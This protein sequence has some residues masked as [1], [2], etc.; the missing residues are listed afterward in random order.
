MHCVFRADSGGN[1][2]AN[3]KKTYA[4][5]TD[6][7]NQTMSSAYIYIR[8]HQT[9]CSWIKQSA[10]FVR[11]NWYRLVRSI[12]Q[13]YDLQ[14]T[15]VQQ[16][17]WRCRQGRK[18]YNIY[19]NFSQLSMIR[20]VQ[21]PHT[22]NCVSLEL[23]FSMKTYVFLVKLLEALKPN[24]RS[25]EHTIVNWALAIQSELLCLKRIHYIIVASR[26]NC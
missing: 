18:I 11:A 12:S 17:M 22:T 7:V 3:S 19:R 24:L 26:K 15:K 13:S 9:V 23:N 10:L 21:P 4:V 5:P 6:W 25:G 16:F 2:S 1:S 20:F 8:Y 14:Y